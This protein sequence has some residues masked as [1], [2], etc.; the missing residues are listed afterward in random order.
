MGKDSVNPQVWSLFMTNK[1]HAMAKSSSPAGRARIQGKVDLTMSMQMKSQGLPDKHKVQSG[2][3]S[4][5]RRPSQWLS[6]SRCLQTESMRV[7]EASRWSAVKVPWNNML[8]R[9]N[10]DNCR[11]SNSLTV[12]TESA[13]LPKELATTVW[14]PIRS[15]K[16]S[17]PRR[18][19]CWTVEAKP[20]WILRITTE[21]PSRDIPAI[22]TN[23][24]LTFTAWTITRIK[25]RVRH[26]KADFT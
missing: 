15:C 16:V 22:A 11:P 26:L 4:Q 17:P 10:K 12:T 14:T 1:L 7:R 21:F 25:E 24:S 8:S 9:E 2:F 18:R 5:T 23:A 6:I 13:I 3:Q 19:S 20:S